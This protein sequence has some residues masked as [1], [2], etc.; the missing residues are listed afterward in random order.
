MQ[1]PPHLEGDLPVNTTS[2]ELT[3]IQSILNPSFS[4]QECLSHTHLQCVTDLSWQIP[5]VTSAR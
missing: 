4:D 3:V 5:P 1:C 2:R